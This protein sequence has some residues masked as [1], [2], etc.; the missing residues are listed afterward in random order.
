MAVNVDI[1]RTMRSLALAKELPNWVSGLDWSELYASS[2]DNQDRLRRLVLDTFA[3]TPVEVLRQKC[4]LF[5]AHLEELEFNQHKVDWQSLAIAVDNM[6]GM[7]H[8]LQLTKVVLRQ[9]YD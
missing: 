5:I 1:I 4:P 8:P 9:A 7:Y 6:G 3:Y 2:E